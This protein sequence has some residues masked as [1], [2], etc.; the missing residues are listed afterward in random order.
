MNIY[1]LQLPSQSKHILSQQED[2]DVDPVFVALV[3]RC[4]SQSEQTW[5]TELAQ[6]NHKK[7]DF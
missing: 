5:Q 7:V 2:D 1:N 3:R 6:R 4:V